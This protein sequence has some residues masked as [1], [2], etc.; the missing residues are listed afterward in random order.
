[1]YCTRKIP[2]KFTPKCTFHTCFLF[3]TINILTLLTLYERNEHVASENQSGELVH[4]NRGPVYQSEGSAHQ[5][6]DPVH[7]STEEQG[8]ELNG[9]REMTKEGDYYDS[10]EDE[11]THITDAYITRALSHLGS[12]TI[13]ECEPRHKIM[14]MKTHKCASST[15]QNV[16]MR[17]VRTYN[18]A[19]FPD[20]TAI[21][22]EKLR[23]Y[24]LHKSRGNAGSTENTED[25]EKAENIGD[26]QDTGKIEDMDVVDRPGKG[27]EISARNMEDTR[28]GVED[29]ER[30]K[31]EGAQPILVAVP[32]KGVYIGSPEHFNIERHIASPGLLP[33][34]RHADVFVAH[35]RL[36][37]AQMQRLMHPDALWVT[38]VRD[39]RGLFPSL[40]SYYKL[41][42]FY[43]M[44]LKSFLQLPLETMKTKSRFAA[45]M[46]A[47]QMTFDLG[48]NTDAF[49][50]DAKIDAL[51][52]DI[53]VT[54][55]L[56]LV[57]ERMDES[58]ALLGRALCWPTQDL[59]ALD[60][61]R[62]MHKGEELRQEEIDK[63]E[64]LNYL[65]VRLY[66]H[67]ARKFELLT[68]AFGKTR[69][70]KEVEALRAARS[71]WVDFCVEDV[72]AGRSRKT[73]FKE[74]S[75]N[76]WG[77]RLA[78][79]EHRTCESLAWNTVQFF[80]YF[81]VFQERLRLC[82]AE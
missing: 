31:K 46:G 1:M 80:D 64:Q 63:L 20:L 14:Y 59:V 6:G 77:F 49:Y 10:P 19:V 23:R 32:K 22:E 5:K 13:R 54:F 76:V 4:Q 9:G 66:R 60:K 29:E 12:R 52:R 53:E 24:F 28:E 21:V 70:Q 65:D 45:V 78:R 43:G 38:V 74:Y 16:I 8:N 82:E 57:A 48:H 42:S 62:R 79:P 25:K 26:T 55:D 33:P 71:Q 68:R 17:H 67:F 58:L 7:G 81:R 72:V 30:K 47:N 56:V 18:T 15:L 3:I 75:G 51:I 39:P 35:T 73:S 37:A 40:Y 41:H 2:V 27:D 61:N 34:S 36:D 11:A 69:L 50:D 44:S